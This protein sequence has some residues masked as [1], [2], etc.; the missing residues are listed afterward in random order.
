MATYDSEFMASVTFTLRVVPRDDQKYAYKLA[1][2][3]GPQG[4]ASGGGR[5]LDCLLAWECKRT[6]HTPGHFCTFYV[7]NTALLCCCESNRAGRS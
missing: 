1:S 7:F 4:Y 2:L 5:F 6:I 3:E